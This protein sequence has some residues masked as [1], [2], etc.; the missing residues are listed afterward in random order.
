[1]RPDMDKVIVERPRSGG[2]ARRPK[3]IRKRE[4]LA[5]NDLLPSREGYR[6][7]WTSWT[8]HLNEHLGPLRRYLQSQ[9]GRPWN[10]VY[11]EI[12]RHLRL[13]SAVQSHVLD[14]LWDYVEVNTRLVNGVVCSTT[15]R[16]IGESRS[17]WR[18]PP[19]YYV[20]PKSGLLKG[21]RRSSRNQRPVVK[22]VFLEI[23][24]R[25]QWHQ[26]NGIWFEIEL[27]GPTSNPLT[28][29]ELQQPYGTYRYAS[30]RQLG[31]REVRDAERRLAEISKRKRLSSASG[32]CFP[33]A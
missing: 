11:S 18:Q 8:K 6:R 20:C 33:T 9:V 14:H 3:G 13:D 21:V 26:V 5:M 22:P 7:R 19:L 4:R 1:M 31:K 15:G 28:L 17:W 2:G 32:K 23:D 29:G 30:K 12:S 25:R 27:P 16:P 10:K 24:A